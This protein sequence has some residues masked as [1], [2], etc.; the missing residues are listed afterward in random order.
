MGK[1]AE[2]PGVN[3]LLVLL[4]PNHSSPGDGPELFCGPFGP[5]LFFHK[6]FAWYDTVRL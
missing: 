4:L 6:V 1:E 3:G 2:I 5:E